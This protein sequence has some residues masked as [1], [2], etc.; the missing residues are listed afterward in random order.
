MPLQ[1]LILHIVKPQKALGVRE[2]CDTYEVEVK[3]SE[4]FPIPK[5]D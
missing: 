3:V 5:T 2:T 1:L 4:R